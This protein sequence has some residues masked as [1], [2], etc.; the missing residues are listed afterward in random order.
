MSDFMVQDSFE[1]GQQMNWK[2]PSNLNLEEVDQRLMRNILASREVMSYREEDEIIWCG[3]KSGIYFVKLGYTLLE[4][5]GRKVD[6]EAKVC[7]NNACL[8]KAGAFSWLEGNSRILTRDDSKEWGLWV[9]FIVCFIR[10]RRKMWIIF[11]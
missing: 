1:L 6:W 5:G 4:A 10:W 9:P 11:Y 8:S 7:W 2:D 3:A